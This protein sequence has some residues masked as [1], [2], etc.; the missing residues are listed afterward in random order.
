MDRYEN[1]LAAE[2]K[3]EGRYSA[4]SGE[5]FAR[6]YSGHPASNTRSV[7]TMTA[8]AESVVTEFAMAV[9]ATRPTGWER[10]IVWKVEY[11]TAHQI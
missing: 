9:T 1:A 10:E 4:R 2:P 11:F 3:Q 7:A 6:C 8:H 5:D